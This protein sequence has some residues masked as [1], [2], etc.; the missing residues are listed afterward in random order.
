MDEWSVLSP[1]ASYRVLA[2]WRARSTL[3]DAFE[4]SHH[5]IR[6][7]QTYLDYLR[8]RFAAEGWRRWYTDD[9]PGILPM[10]EDPESVTPEMLGEGSAYLRERDA[11]D[12]ESPHVLFLPAFMSQEP[13]DG[14]HIPPFVERPLSPADAL[15]FGVVPLVVLLAETLAAF[16]FALWAVNRADVTGY[17]MAEES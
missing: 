14:D 7:R 16:L 5:G 4:V 13:L 9:P 3:E 6:Y 2:K 10:I 15:A 12:G 11:A 1:F 17:A 8:G